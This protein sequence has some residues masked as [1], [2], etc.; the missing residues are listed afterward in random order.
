M[1]SKYQI[2]IILS[3]F[4]NGKHCV[5]Y[6]KYKIIRPIETTLSVINVKSTG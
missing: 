4:E 1:Q 3:F 5:K 6:K 2:Y